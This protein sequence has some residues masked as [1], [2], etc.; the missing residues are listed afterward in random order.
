M[1]KIA[2]YNCSSAIDIDEFNEFSSI[3]CP[4]CKHEVKVPKIV[5]DYI[6]EEILS[7]N[8]YYKTYKGHKANSEETLVIKII[9]NFSDQ[10]FSELRIKL[11]LV[12]D[13]SRLTR[14]KSEGMYFAESP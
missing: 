7:S 12:P 11:S 6:F 8:R 4:K 9:E 3:H 10:L 2:C 14:I 5:G 1:N 13:L